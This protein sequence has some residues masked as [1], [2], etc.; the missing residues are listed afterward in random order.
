MSFYKSEL[1]VR[2]AT[3]QHRKRGREDQTE[4][5]WLI[6]RLPSDGMQCVFA[7]GNQG[8]LPDDLI[9]HILTFLAMH[10]LHPMIKCFE[11]GACFRVDHRRK[12]KRIRN[13]EKER[14]K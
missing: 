1:V 6:H 13:K 14:E 12:S 3:R 11:E 7:V 2:P 4:V 5:T 8:G 9:R 10:D